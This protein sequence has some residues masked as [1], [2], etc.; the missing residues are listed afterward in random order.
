MDRNAARERTVSSANGFAAIAVG[1]LLVGVPIYLLLD[2]PSPAMIGLFVVALL[3]AIACFGGLYMLQPNQAALFLLFGSYRGTDRS[4]GLRW[5]NPFYVKKKVS[6]RARNF[7]SDKLKVNDLRGNPIEIAAAI[8][9]KIDDTAKAIF[10]VDN[11]EGYV[12]T[13][14]E[15]AIRHLALAYAYDDVDEPATGK[16]RAVTLRSGTDEVATALRAELENRFEQAG[17]VVVDAKLSHLAYAPEIAGTMLR[18]QQAE[19]VVSARTKIVEG[20][21]GMVELALNGLAERGLLQLDDERRAAMVSNLLVVLCAD[22][23]ATPVV[24]TGTLYH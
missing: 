15:S 3:L 11:Y 4:E 10:D 14:A 18:R 12:L 21:V 8:V 5:A 2:R 9:W 1:V 13:Q 24:N 6:V 17:I 19:A 20:A 7:N 16:A 23:D 22:R